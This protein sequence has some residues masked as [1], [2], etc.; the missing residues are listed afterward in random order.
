MAKDVE[1]VGHNGVNNTTSR[2]EANATII[3]SV[4]SAEKAAIAANRAF[5]SILGSLRID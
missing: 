4:N 3:A 2:P 1:K 5:V